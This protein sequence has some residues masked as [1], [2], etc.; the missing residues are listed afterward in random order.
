MDPTIVAS[1]TYC[2]RCTCCN[3]SNCS[4]SCNCK[5]RH[6]N[7]Q[8]IPS[9]QGFTL[10]E[11][12]L[13]V[14]TVA[15]ALGL[16]NSSFSRAIADMRSESAMR[17]LSTLFNMARQEA[18]LRGRNV[19]VCAVDAEGRCTRDWSHEHVIVAFV[20]GNENRR[21]EASETSVR[22][23]RWPLSQG[24]LSWRASLA[25]AYIEFETTGGTWQNGTLYYCP[26]SRDARQARALVLSHSGRTYLP[27]DSNADGIREDRNGKNLRC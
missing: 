25:R 22:E 12:L 21:R 20:D 18:L 8:A 3:R 5:S 14:A 27:G 13:V 10:I 4:N 16:T 9:I 24:V 1:K 11:L 6:K 19:T 23:L 26:V 2:G 7:R 15:I 17:H